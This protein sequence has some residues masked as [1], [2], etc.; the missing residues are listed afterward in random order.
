MKHLTW[1]P[2]QFNL[3]EA[4]GELRELHN[5]LYYLEF[6]QLP[7]EEA[8]DDGYKTWIADRLTK[9]IFNEVSLYV[10]LDHAYHH[11]NWAWNARRTPEERV[12]HFTD[13]D[14]KRWG[15][16]PKSKPFADLWPPKDDVRRRAQDP[17]HWKIH[18]CP[19]RVHVQLAQQKLG[20]LCALVD[21]EVGG[22]PPPVPDAR[23][24]ILL[25]AGRKVEEIPTGDTYITAEKADA[26]PAHLTEREFARRMHKIYAELNQ[27]W[28]SRRDKTF[29][30]KISAIQR[31]KYFPPKSASPSLCF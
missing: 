26:T 22:T 2:M 9:H 10:S 23:T 18:Y 1:K 11:L 24:A 3:R 17:Q 14:W 27:A 16:F 13:R 20:I 4:Y 28:N 21:R 8:E 6:G 31:R 25:L 15:K 12:W 30:T 5:R 19:V 29:V 7:V